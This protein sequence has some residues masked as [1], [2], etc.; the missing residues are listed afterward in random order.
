VNYIK[1]MSMVGNWLLRVVK[2]KETD[3]KIVL[4]TALYFFLSIESGGLV[5][6]EMACSF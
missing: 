1:K 5:V 6:A 2:M 4:Y 3:H